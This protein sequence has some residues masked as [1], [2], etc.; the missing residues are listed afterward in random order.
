M[1][2]RLL[3]GKATAAAI[4]EELAAQVAERVRRG[5]P[6]PG[7]AAILVGDNPASQLYVRN[8]HKACQQ[9]GMRSWIHH[10]PADIT[11]ARLLGLIEQLNADPHVH[12][13][14]VQLPLPPHLDESAVQEAVDPRKD[15]DAF[16]PENAGLLTLGRPRFYPC[17]PHGVV[18]L[19]RRHGYETAGKEIVVIGRSNIVGK[20]L[21]LMLLQKRTV[22]NPAAGDATVTI[23]HTRSQDLARLCQ[24]AQ[25]VVAA[26][27][28]PAMIT[29]EMVAPGAVVVD[30]GINAVAGRIVGDVHPAV[31]E[32]AAA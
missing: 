8:K 15:V 4:R 16:H 17:T 26:A 6:P 20:P 19:L 18:Q 24:R 2:A 31:A 9:V 22:P 10:L 30:V 1:T 5:L 32:K 23:V 28:V 29:P 13:I 14:L 7:L 12:G 27:G 25:I 11:A 3:D 21:A